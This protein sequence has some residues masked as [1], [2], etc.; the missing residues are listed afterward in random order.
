MCDETT[1]EYL[2]IDLGSNGKAELKAVFSGY[3]W[4]R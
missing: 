3:S 1:S 2:K 4:Y